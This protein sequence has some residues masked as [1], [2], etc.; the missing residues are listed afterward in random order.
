MRRISIRH[1]KCVKNLDFTIPEKNGVYLLAGAN[2][3]GKSTLLVCL[4]RLCNPFAFAN[5]FPT[6]RDARNIDQYKL[7]SIV[8]QDKS[9]SIAFRK[10]DARW[11]PTP[12]KGS[13]K[14]LQRFGF[15]DVVFIRAESGRFDVNKEE[16]RKGNFINANQSTIDAMNNIFETTRFKGLKRLKNAN[17]RGKRA[18]YFYIIADGGGFYSEKRFSSGELAVLRLVDS[19]T[20]IK[21]KSLILLDEAEMAL[22]P[23]VQKKL[24]DFIREKANEYDLMVFISTHST[25]LINSTPKTEIIGLEKSSNGDIEVI[26]PCYPAKAVGSIDFEINNNPDYIYF[27]EDDMAKC[28]LQKMLFRYIKLEPKHF[29]ALWRVI[30]VAGYEQTALFAK[31]TQKQ[32]F[33]KSRV[34]AVLDEDAFVDGVANNTKFRELLNKNKELIK[35]LNCTPEVWI[36]EQL[37][38]GA[39]NMKEALRRN[40]KC[41][42]HD[43]VS[44]P[45]YSKCSMK[46]KRKEAKKKVG[47]A[48]EAIIDHSGDKEDVVIDTLIELLINQMTDGEIKRT[49]APLFN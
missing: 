41:E 31:H 2:G 27:V 14:I 13:D 17:G 5:G 24:L 37:A 18:T 45:E 21:K 40:F 6:S 33:N 35:N 29:N 20:T 39:R 28:L 47:I 42:L 26:F 43:I 25:T 44:L 46:S 1:A 8:Y 48:I 3:A 36:V 4:E 12:K 15:A 30:P 49:I 34:F 23:R 7:T 32:L 16:V 22:H 10:G 19:L 9:S 38:N 11:V